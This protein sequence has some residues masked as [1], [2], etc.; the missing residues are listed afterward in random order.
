MVKFLLRTV[1][2]VVFLLSFLTGMVIYQSYIVKSP[3]IKIHEIAYQAFRNTDR[4]ITI[5]ATS[6]ATV[7]K[8]FNAKLT[9]V[10]HSK[11]GFQVELQNSDIKYNKNIGQ[12]TR[13]FTAPANVPNGNYCVELIMEWHPEFSVTEKVVNIETG[14][15]TIHG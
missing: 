14:C 1:G 13:V 3:P 10:L 2:A 12:L 15:F 5:T 7:H 4:T 11:D 9:R 6:K 8:T